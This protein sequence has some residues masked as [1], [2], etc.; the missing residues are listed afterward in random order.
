MKKLFA[1]TIFCLSFT[2]ISYADI[3]SVPA[4]SADSS[5]PW[6]ETF[7]TTVVNNQNGNISGAAGTG[8]TIN[9]KAATVDEPDMY[10]AANPRVRDAELLGVGVDTFASGSLTQNS[11]V[12]SGCVPATDASLTSSISACVAYVNGYRISKGATSETYSASMDTYVDLSQNAVYT[13]SAVANGASQPVV[14]SNSARIAKVVTSGTAITSVTDL[15]NR[16]LGGL[17]TPSNYRSGL[18]VSRDS[19]TTITVFPGTNRPLL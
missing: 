15:S 16:R 10:Q 17:V 6:L 4:A 8:A 12:A 7:R 14:A 3:I 2:N 19:A 9:I 5:T 18:F 13:L 11:F 1:L